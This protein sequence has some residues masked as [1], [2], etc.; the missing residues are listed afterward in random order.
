[1]KKTVVLK[2]G[3]KIIATDLVDD[4]EITKKESPGWEKLVENAVKR[5]NENHRMSKKET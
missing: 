2:C 5:L 3:N 1:M 4:N